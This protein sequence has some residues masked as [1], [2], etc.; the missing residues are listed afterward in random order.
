LEGIPL[1]EFKEFAGLTVDNIDNE[2]GHTHKLSGN[3][4]IHTAY[5]SSQM[6]Y[7]NAL[8]YVFVTN[9]TQPAKG[10]RQ[11]T[12][13]VILL[14]PK[15]QHAADKFGTLESANMSKGKDVFVFH[16]GKVN[17]LFFSVICADALRSVLP[18]LSMYKGAD[19]LIFNPQL[20]PAPL[21]RGFINFIRSLDYAPEGARAAIVCLNWA[22]GTRLTDAT[23]GVFGISHGYSG[24]YFKGQLPTKY[25]DQKKLL[26]NNF[27]K[28]SQGYQCEHI[29][30]WESN[31]R[32]HVYRYS[33]RS[34]SKIVD[35]DPSAEKSYEPNAS[36]YYDWSNKDSSWATSSPKCVVAWSWVNEV[37]G[38]RLMCKHRANH[39]AHIGGNEC[40][41]TRLVYFLNSFS[42]DTAHKLPFER[43]DFSLDGAYYGI[44]DEL[45]GSRNIDFSRVRDRR[46]AIER[47]KNTLCDATRLPSG[48]KS[49]IYG[50]RWIMGHDKQNIEYVINDE[51]SPA[52]VIYLP[53]KRKVE[54]TR[55]AIRD[56][57]GDDHYDKV[58]EKRMLYG[59]MCE[60]KGMVY[61][62]TLES[63]ISNPSRARNN[64]SLTD[65]RRA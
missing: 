49:L 13:L 17:A 63:D 10:R 18:I 23:E 24:I 33:I 55:T 40:C 25:S 31:Y 28:G 35:V 4:A 64:R 21:H 16:C 3:V 52:W 36:E 53:S 57:C 48:F 51:P 47:V 2:D 62:K 42:C 32:E 44:V 54:A 45:A 11:N 19:W 37:F 65:H 58:I 1:D 43:E 7:V 46:E 12:Q 5:L 34:F 60:K 30:A 15:I 38:R 50:Y 26:F 61:T 41:F 6:P 20:N 22:S 39:I 9:K 14:Q 27:A 59:Y 29:T 56:L 8:A